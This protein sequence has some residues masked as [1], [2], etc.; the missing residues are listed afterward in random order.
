M[1]A[2]ILEPK[3]P[4]HQRKTY[5]ILSPRP[6][7]FKDAGCE[8][9]RCRHMRDGWKSIVDEATELGRQQADYIRRISGRSF[10]ESRDE[11]GLTVFV[12][13]AGQRCFRQHTVKLERE[14]IYVVRGGDHRGNPRGERRVH[15]RPEEWVEDFAEHQERLI[16][17]QS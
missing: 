8:E 14:E 3:L 9:A 15:G 7:H 5:Q 1:G 2:F 10:T 12:F 16:R 11:T 6:T 13:A 4:A 17:A